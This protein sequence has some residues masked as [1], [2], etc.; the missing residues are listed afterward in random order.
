MNKFDQSFISGEELAKLKQIHNV[1]NSDG[2][3]TVNRTYA[4]VV[5][6]QIF[7]G[8]SEKYIASLGDLHKFQTKN[9][10]ASI[11]NNVVMECNPLDVATENFK[12]S[13]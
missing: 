3:V 10:N 5:K 9:P 4:D 1:V 6:N 2:S 11:C 12:F 7:T 13:M 8:I